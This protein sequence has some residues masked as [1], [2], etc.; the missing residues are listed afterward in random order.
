MGRRC[1]GVNCLAGQAL[2]EARLAEIP[3]SG[4][5]A[6]S[7]AAPLSAPKSLVGWRHGMPGMRATDGW[8][9]SPFDLASLT[10]CL[11]RLNNDLAAATVTIDMRT[12]TAF[13]AAALITA[14]MLQLPGSAQA[15]SRA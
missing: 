7:T 9:E 1:A 15:G 10:T 14:L 2:A 13:A 5:Y 3:R 12:N 4:F 11:R 6:P 8:P